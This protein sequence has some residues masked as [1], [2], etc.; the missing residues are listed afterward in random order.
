VAEDTL[1]HL[2]FTTEPQLLQAVTR[3]PAND[4]WRARRDWGQRRANERNWGLTT[5][6][7][8]QYNSVPPARYASPYADPDPTKGGWNWKDQ[9]GYYSPSLGENACI[10]IIDTGVQINHDEFAEL[11]GSGRPTGKSRVDLAVSRITG[12]TNPN[13]G[14]GHGTHC[15]GTAGGNYRGLAKHAQLRSVRV[16]N[17]GGSG[18][19]ADVIAGINFVVD[20]KVDKKANIAS[21]SLGGGAW[22]PVDEAINAADMAGI[23]CVVAAGNSNNDAC[24][25]SPARASM[26]ITVAASD[27]ADQIASFSSFGPCI[28]SIGPGVTVTSAWIN[29]ALQT[30]WYNDISGTSMATPHVAG[31]IACRDTSALH[32]PED[33]KAD[34]GVDQTMGKILG[35]TGNKASTLNALIFSQWKGPN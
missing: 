8:N 25:N 30:D 17:N 28:N 11:D 27:S 14:N 33:V 24:N 13:D 7:D 31:A 34:L 29:S 2:N 35:L 21:L 9:T 12:D 3:V 10:W 4:A 26:A 18:S 22:Q 1:I 19:W 5:T 20:Q 15:M 16:L 6:P 23:I 32:D